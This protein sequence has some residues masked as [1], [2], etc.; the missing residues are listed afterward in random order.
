MVV[1]KGEKEYFPLIIKVSFNLSA[2]GIS[3]A[4]AE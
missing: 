2:L 3:E 4:A 1:R